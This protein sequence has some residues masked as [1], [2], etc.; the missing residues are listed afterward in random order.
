[1]EFFH[2]PI[3]REEYEVME[4]NFR[5]WKPSRWVELDL[6]SKKVRT[7]NGGR[8]TI[9]KSSL[10]FAEYELK[11]DQLELYRAYHKFKFRPESEVLDCLRDKLIHV[12]N[13]AILEFSKTADSDENR[14]KM[15][16]MILSHAKEILS[17]LGFTLI[18]IHFHFA[19]LPLPPPPPEIIAAK[20][21]EPIDKPVKTKGK[22]SVPDIKT[23]VGELLVLRGSFD[24]KL[25]SLEDLA[26]LPPDKKSI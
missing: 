1:M 5:I 23:L 4:A 18:D 8:Y 2:S 26:E 15:S 10:L 20:L 24:S 7:D 16:Q 13:W 22:P 6:E 17:D 21:G 3:A 14:N 9:V 12:E 19:N 25:K 11:I